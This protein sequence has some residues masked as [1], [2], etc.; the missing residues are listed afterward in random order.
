MRSVEDA[1]LTLVARAL[2][3]AATARAESRGAHVRTD[4]PSRDDAI[5]QH[6]Q[7]VGLKPTGEAVL[8]EPLLTGAA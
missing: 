3:V 7:L 5:W 4:F 6:T 1:A 2:L 8:L